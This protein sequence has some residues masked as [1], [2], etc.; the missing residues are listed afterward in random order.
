MQRPQQ[1]PPTRWGAAQQQ[2][3]AASFGA[4][5][6]SGA[7]QAAHQQQ[8]GEQQLQQQQLLHQRQQQQQPHPFQQLQA[9]Q[10]QALSWNTL[11]PQQVPAAPVAIPSPGSAVRILANIDV[12][13]SRPLS[14][15]SSLLA[16]ER[17]LS[18][19]K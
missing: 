1:Q 3:P 8:Q 10:S 12:S 17:Q 16:A 11:P 15:A 6:L 4:F 18:T 2:Q 5:S 19:G 13:A 14:S 9:Q 7:Q